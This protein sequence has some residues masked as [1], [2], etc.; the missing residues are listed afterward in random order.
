MARLPVPGQDKGTW[1]GIL[2]EFLEVSHAADGTLAPNT[3]NTTQ[4]APNSVTSTALAD[5]SVN[6]A[7]I[8]D[9]SVTEAQ[10]AAAV[11]ASLSS[12]NS[13]IQQINGKTPISGAITLTASDVNALTQTTAD[14]RYSSKDFLNAADYG[15]TPG[16]SASTND[17]AIASAISAGRM[18]SMPVYLG[19]GTYHISVPINLKA[20]ASFS[21]GD[22]IFGAGRNATI[23]IQDTDRAEILQVGGFVSVYEDFTIKH[24]S[25]SP[26]SSTGDGLV[27]YKSAYSTFKRIQVTNAARSIAIA[28]VSTYEPGTSSGSGNYMFSN[29]FEDITILRYAKNGLFLNGYAGGSTGSTWTNVYVHN[30]TSGGAQGTSTG[31]A[32]D[33]FLCDAVFNQLNVEDLNGSVTMLVN[34]QSQVIVNGMHIERVNVPAGYKYISSYGGASVKINGIQ[35]VQSDVATSGTGTTTLFKATAGGQLVVDNILLNNCLQTATSGVSFTIGEVGDTNNANV[36]EVGYYGSNSSPSFTAPTLS[37][38]NSGLK[39]MGDTLYGISAPAVGKM[40]AMWYSGSATSM[41]TYSVVPVVYNMADT[42]DDATY[43]TQNTGTGSITLIRTGVYMIRGQTKISV[44]SANKSISMLVQIN[45]TSL[46]EHTT[47]TAGIANGSVTTE[48]SKIVRATT[49]NSTLT[50][51]HYLDTAASYSGGGINET[52]V[53]VTY[54]GN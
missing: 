53:E 44:S 35:F 52:R 27:F 33:I 48:V 50:V 36:L 11:Q 46:A 3:V 6:A 47:M 28:Q 31:N 19:I 42:N 7:I 8:V 20:T 13:S 15:W 21:G 45:G 16:A 4:L 49:A 12:A 54:L 26:S 18:A 41:G 9:G 14:A 30:L 38:G 17:A 43:F 22:Y 29:T 23:I 2:N 37:S 24:S 39:R 51:G 34:A 10:L 1:G 25:D 5:N 40:C 32:V